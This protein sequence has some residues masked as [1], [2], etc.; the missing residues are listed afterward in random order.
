MT[1]PK[2]DEF[3]QKL[4]TA[5]GDNL[6]A[7]IL[8]GSAVTGEFH[9]RH[10]DLNV[11][12]VVDR[13][14]ARRIE[15]LH[16]PV[17]W[18][19]KQGHGPPLIF[20]L[21]ELTR[22]ADVFAM[23]LLDMK[24]HHQVLFGADVLA[25]ISVPLHYHAIQVEREL[26]TGWLRLR[27]AMLA[28]P[29]KPKLYLDLMAS[30]FSSFTTLF[31]HALIA[32]GEAPAANK[33]EAIARIGQFAGGDPGGFHTIL[34]FREGKKEPQE[35]DIGKTLNLYFAFVEAVTDKFDRWLDTKA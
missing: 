21:E 27:H 9:S 28:A 14:D 6:R 17:Q 7:V 1:N 10:S 26:R 4:K 22:S 19:S 34:D 5:A 8:Y 13:A 33:R 24:A 30:S 31:R 25:D 12:C 23:E 35:I 2:L 15:A 29:R 16:E 20:T 18:W 11:L 32:M 3:V